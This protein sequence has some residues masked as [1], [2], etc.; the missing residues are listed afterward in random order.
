MQKYESVVTE[1]RYISWLGSWLSECS[2]IFGQKVTDCKTSWIELKVIISK[3]GLHFTETHISARQWWFS[4]FIYYNCVHWQ[5]RAWNIKFGRINF[6]LCFDFWLVR[7][8]LRSP[9]LITLSLVKPASLHHL[10]LARNP[11]PSSTLPRPSAPVSSPVISSY[12]LHRSSSTCSL[13]ASPP[14]SCFLST[15][16]P[17][18]TH[19]H[20]HPHSCTIH[21]NT[22]T[23]GASG[24]F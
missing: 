7:S 5:W 20:I 23:V 13:P 4:Y 15:V 24:S 14:S 6:S 10:L 9:V 12:Q 3:I 16:C 22:Y 1:L 11:N 17:D 19:K 8:L 18:L 21:T 2:R